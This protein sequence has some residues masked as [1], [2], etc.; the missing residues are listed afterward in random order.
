M[1]WGTQNTPEW[2]LLFG[3]D[4]KYSENMIQLETS[5]IIRET[6]A[7]LFEMFVVGSG[8]QSI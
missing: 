4:Y 2:L 3:D 1:T 7:F 5:I 6:T 8:W